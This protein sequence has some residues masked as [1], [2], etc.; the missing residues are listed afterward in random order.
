M[1]RSIL[2]FDIIGLVHLLWAWL[3]VFI[4]ILLVGCTA[5]QSS[6]PGSS[7]IES[8]SDNKIYS[9]EQSGQLACNVPPM[10]DIS[11]GSCA[12][13]Q[14]CI[15]GRKFSD[16]LVEKVEDCD[17]PVIAQGDK[18][19]AVAAV[20][21][22]LAVD[23]PPSHAA[24]LFVNIDNNW[25]PADQLLD[26]VWNHGG[27]CE[28]QF[29]FQ[30]ETGASGDE[31]LLIVMSERICHMPLDQDEIA[32]GE[33]DVAMNECVNVRYRVTDNRLE[34]LAETASEAPCPEP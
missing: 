25:C 33:S 15:E 28:T 9:C 12:Q 30:W 18:S 14:N 11:S 5:A 7:Q 32:A 26:P 17:P 27:Y 19:I 34:R 23:G 16:V 31:M 29:Q 8:I 3:L 10:R 4:G 24:Y 6:S 1:K 22:Q 13:L 21:V 2:R 20:A